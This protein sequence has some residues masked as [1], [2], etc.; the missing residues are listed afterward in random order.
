MDTTV[1]SSSNS[2]D[3]IVITAAAVEDYIAET[4]DVFLFDQVFELDCM[5]G[6]VSDHYPVFAEFKV[7]SDT[8]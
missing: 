5:P 2:Y 4:A 7:S 6:E 1:A 8:D 3:R